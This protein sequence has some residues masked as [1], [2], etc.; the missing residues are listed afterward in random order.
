MLRPHAPRYSNALS[1]SN[2]SVALES[3]I[4]LDT[5]DS[6]VT[7]TKGVNKCGFKLQMRQSYGLKRSTK[8]INIGML[9]SCSNVRSTTVR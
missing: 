5:L 9:S 8:E 2:K 3:S 7:I 6:L 1:T 4:D